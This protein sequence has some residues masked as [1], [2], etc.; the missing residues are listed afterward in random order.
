MLNFIKIINFTVIESLELSFSAGLTV[1]TGESGAGKSVLFEAL[2][3]LLG[4]RADATVVRAGC[5]QCELSACFIVTEWVAAQH[6]LQEQALSAE[7]DECILRRVIT[8][9]GRS[10]SF[11]NG[12]PVTLQMLRQLA[13]YLVMVHGQHEHQ[14]L[15]QAQTQLSYLDRFARHAKKI[16]QV[17]VAYDDWSAAQRK[18]DIL[19]HAM[20]ERSTRLEFLQ[21]Q[22]NELQQLD[23]VEGEYEQLE[24]EHR[25]LANVDTLLQHYHTALTILSEQESTAVIQQLHSALIAVAALCEQ[26]NQLMETHSMLQ[27]ASIQVEE[28]IANLQHLRHELSADPERLQFVSQRLSQVQSMAR[29]HRIPVA[30]LWQLQQDF[31]A[32]FDQLSA[33][34]EQ[35]ELL[36]QQVMNKA[37]IYTQYAKQLSQSRQ[38]AA[39]RL[40]R[41][42]T[43]HLQTLGM[44]KAYFEVQCEALDSGFHRQGLEQVRFYLCANPGQPLQLLAK[45]ASGGE[46]SRISLA[47][48]VVMMSF[49]KPPLILFDEVDVGVSGATAEVIGRLLQSLAAEAQLL[50]VTH[51]AQVAALGDQH[52]QVI[53]TQDDSHTNTQVITL[54]KEQRIQE[55]ARILGGIKM[56][57]QTLAH[58]RSLLA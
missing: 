22:L 12:T 45:V 56:T 55:L 3:Y 33:A 24:Q 48:H 34:D 17:H 10:K 11:I 8:A 1:V 47:I 15:L 39:K 25:R 52:I 2:H 58:A 38:R 30:Q 4:A 51:Q 54:N 6:W 40:S 42:I 53:K 9:E 36:T 21:F 44:P 49:I 16:S 37:Q 31:Q 28:S 7:E 23:L 26:E 27:Q 43:Q 14:A 41:S 18:L 57:A 32:E 29:K 20:K 46:L 13:H 5:Q 35:L 50:C 19:K